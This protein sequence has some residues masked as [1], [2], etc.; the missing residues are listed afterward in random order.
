MYSL[1][2][3][4][5]SPDI[6]ECA[7][8]PCFNG[9]QCTDGINTFTCMCE[10]GFEGFVCENSEFDVIPILVTCSNLSLIISFPI[11]D[12]SSNYPEVVLWVF[13]GGG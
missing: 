6:D 8:D 12:P 2:F 11:K 10:P 4:C 7:S 13:F 5:F 3:R 1:V 9:G